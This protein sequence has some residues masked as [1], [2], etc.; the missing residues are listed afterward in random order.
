[1]EDLVPFTLNVVYTKIGHQTLPK[2]AILFKEKEVFETLGF[3]VNLPTLHNYANIFLMKL[4]G[5][6]K[7]QNYKLAESLI[8]Y[9][10]KISLYDYKLSSLDQN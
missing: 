5:G 8:D 6:R 7:H 9:V 10:A 1:M 3:N 2:T 4:F